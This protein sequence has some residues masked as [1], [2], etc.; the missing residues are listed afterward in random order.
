MFVRIKEGGRSVSEGRRWHIGLSGV[1]NGEV[2]IG[3]E[4]WNTGLDERSDCLVMFKEEGLDGLENEEVELLDII[5]GGDGLGGIGRR[6]TG[7]EDT[8]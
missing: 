7:L 5:S 3:E 8:G 4:H 2:G 6:G 1:G